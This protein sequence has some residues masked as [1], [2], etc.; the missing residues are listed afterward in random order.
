MNQGESYIT[1]ISDKTL[2]KLITGKRLFATTDLDQINQV[3]AICICVS[4]L[5]NQTKESNLSS[6]VRTSEETS[7]HLRR[8]QL[9]ILENTTYPGTTREIVLPILN[10]S[11]LKASQD[12]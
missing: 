2:S 3:D 9:V 1:D 4:T 10:R 5:L 8:D 6:V 12:F 7:R 11:G